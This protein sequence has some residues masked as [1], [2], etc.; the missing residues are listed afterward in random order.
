MQFKL[1][2]VMAFRTRLKRRS[3]LVTKKLLW[4][5][6]LFLAWLARGR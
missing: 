6:W 1:I 4:V 5:E 2:S 3:S